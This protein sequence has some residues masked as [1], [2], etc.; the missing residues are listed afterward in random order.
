MVKSLQSSSHWIST[1]WS[2]NHKSTCKCNNNIKIAIDSRLVI[3]I[4]SLRR[5]C[6]SIYGKLLKHKI[7]VTVIYFYLSTSID[8]YLL[9]IPSFHANTL[10]SLQ[11]T[12][13]RQNHWAMAQHAALVSEDL[14][15]MYLP[16]KFYVLG[17]IGLSKQY[18]P[19]SDCFWRSSLIRV[20]AVCHSISIFWMH[21]CIVT[22]N[23]SIFRTIMAIVWGVPNFRI[24]TVWTNFEDSIPCGNLE[25]ELAATG[26][27]LLY[28]QKSV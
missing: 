3:A 4:I 16:Y 26:E 20:Y 25:I 24:F 7:S 19:R 10:N 9:I 13:I 27:Y 6:Q 17:Q 11:N 12:C 8:S 28:G 23:F 1:V 2:G 22:S 21:W 18:R 5:C 15:Q 14:P